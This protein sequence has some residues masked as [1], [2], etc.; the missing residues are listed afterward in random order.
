MAY[1]TGNSEF[2]KLDIGLSCEKAALHANQSFLD[3]EILME[4]A[5]AIANNI[6]VFWVSK[7][8]EFYSSDFPIVVSPHV[9]HVQPMYM[10]LAQ[11]GGELTF[12]LSAEI[13]LSIFDRAYFQDKI[14]MDG[15]FIVATDKEIRR[16]NYLRYMYA[17]QHVFSCNNDFKII[18]FIYKMEGKHPFWQPNYKTEIISGLGK[19]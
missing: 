11:Y 4:F 15:S 16:F 2:S 13:A 17:T 5:D 6:F 9:Q 12:P 19:Y 1:Q 3:G 18:D 10:G 8:K 7:E 14:S